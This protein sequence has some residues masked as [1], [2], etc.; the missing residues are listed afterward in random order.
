MLTSA[1]LICVQDLLGIVVCASQRTQV[2][3]E[4]EV[5]KDKRHDNER[6]LNDS[7]DLAPEHVALNA[8]EPTIVIFGKLGSAQEEL[9]VVGIHAGYYI[10]KH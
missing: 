8:A 9:L 10:K 3:F 1:L 6:N 7:P 4:V 2:R 5:S